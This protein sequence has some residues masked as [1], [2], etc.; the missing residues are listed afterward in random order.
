PLTPPAAPVFSA[1]TRENTAGETPPPMDATTLNGPDTE[2]ATRPG[3]VAR[4]SESVVAWAT[5]RLPGN[6]P[7]GP[8][9]GAEKF[10]AT[11]AS[12][13]LLASRTATTNGL[14]VAAGAATP[15]VPATA[16]ID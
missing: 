7:L 10:T 2:L 1:I 9:V 4:P 13:L 8:D 3:D 6:S 12:K 15:G 14:N 11:P 5:L 16:T